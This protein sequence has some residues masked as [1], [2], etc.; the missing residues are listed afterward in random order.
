MIVI[1][2]WSGSSTI[3]AAA[4]MGSVW[5]NHA[6]QPKRAKMSS[7]AQTRPRVPFADAAIEPRAMRRVNTTGNDAAK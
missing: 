1:E 2:I 3:A 7:N 5:L 6:T 4:C